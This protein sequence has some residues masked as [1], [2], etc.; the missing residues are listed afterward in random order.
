M[1]L[2]SGHRDHWEPGSKA[3]FEYRCY[4]GHDSGDAQAWYRSHRP[5]TILGPEHDNEAWHKDWDDEGFAGRGA[6]GMARSY[7]VKHDTD[8]FEH[9]AWEDEL[10]T[11]PKHFVR[12]DPPAPPKTASGEEVVRHEVDCPECARWQY[13]VPQ[14]HFREMRNDS[15]QPDSMSP[16]SPTPQRLT[17]LPGEFTPLRQS[18]NSVEP[19]TYEPEEVSEHNNDFEGPYGSSP[20][21][22]DLVAEHLGVR[23]HE[24]EYH[25]EHHSMSGFPHRGAHNFDEPEEQ[26]YVHHLAQH[27]EHLPPLV[28]AGIQP[29]FNREP[30]AVVDGH[31]RLAA[32]AEAG[33]SHVPIYVG[34]PRSQHTGAVRTPP[35][36]NGDDSDPDPGIMIAVVPPRRVVKGLPLPEDG[37]HPDNIHV[38][39]A[40]LGKTSEHTPEQIA[41][42]PELIEAWAETEKRLEARVQGAGTFVN[43]GN[44]VLWASVDVP[45]MAAMHVRLVDYLDSHGFTVSDDHGF[46]PHMTL[47]YEKHHV[48]F[49]PK[50]EPATF[51]IR[52]VWCCIG[53][54][55]E[56]F[57]L[58][59]RG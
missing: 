26:A 15:I 23:P 16:W 3:H 29:R 53:G 21:T 39:L 34:Y 1:N 12:P 6:E 14:E 11:H 44:H 2:P 52:E 37:E 30:V 40:Y 25:L 41:D 8:G 59:G 24:V 57:P 54:R 13:H 10:L 19:D 22:H 50:I 31:H 49:L 27:V 5:V 9:S 55:W 4:E 20:D 28:A 33:S 46:V 35:G 47:S 42:L 32:H 7:R 51:T 48:R 17:R 56:S 38:T 45:G 36:P 43:E 18:L 58:R